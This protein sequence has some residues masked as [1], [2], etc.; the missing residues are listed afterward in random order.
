M[1]PVQVELSSWNRFITRNLAITPDLLGLSHEFRFEKGQVRVELPTADNSMEDMTRDQRLSL[2]SYKEEDGR[3]VPTRI[4]VNSV[5]VLVRLNNGVSVPEQVLTRHPNA[6]EL[7]SE[8]QQR[9][10]NQLA[11]TH[12]DIA[13]KA[14]DVW[15]RTLRWKSNNGTIGRPEVHGYESGW[16]TYLLND[17]TK[18]RFWAS[19]HVL[20]VPPGKPITL[21]EWQEV[22]EVLERSQ[23][24]PVCIDL[25][26]DGMEHLNVGDLQR[27]VVDLAV[28]CEAYMRAR[29]M[30]NLPGGLTEAVKRYIDEAN[31][32]QVL[33]HF[34]PEILSEE[35]K[36]LLKSINSSLQQLFNARNAIL[37]SGYKEDL[38]TTEC[39][40]YLDTTQK[41]I[42]IG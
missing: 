3:K 28:A 17:E 31:I 29:V 19:P 15:L 16:S 34:F 5:D 40:K 13:E 11:E 26:F 33:N 35:Q 24:P 7:L 27:S 8:E 9:Q 37:H 23:E 14:F 18:W 36:N 2:L 12:G 25:M 32:R 6:Y 22:Q 20:T 41:L 21:A 38:T 39:N 1:I 42:S 30:Q 10:L 4:W